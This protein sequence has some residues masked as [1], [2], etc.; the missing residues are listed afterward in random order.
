MSEADEFEDTPWTIDDCDPGIRDVVQLLNDHGFE[1]A[2]SGDGV[3]K[4]ADPDWAD[5]HW[6]IIPAPHVFLEYLDSGEDA[7]DAASRLE[8]LKESEPLLVD[9]EISI[10][11]PEEPLIYW[12]VI[13]MGADIP[14]SVA[15]VDASWPA[16][17]GSRYVEDSNATAP[18]L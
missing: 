7:R 15:L 12:V 6:Q 11:E 14:E 16:E 10:I 3:T 18:D 8:A 13:L 2:D 5:G 1:T 4:F 9:F 17:M